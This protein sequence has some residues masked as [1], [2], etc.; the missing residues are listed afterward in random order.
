MIR[1]WNTVYDVLVE[2]CGA[3]RSCRDMFLTIANTPNGFYTNNRGFHEYRFQGA[4]GFGGKLWQNHE[5]RLHVDCY[6]E[7]RTP[8]RDLMI[9]RANAR[10]KDL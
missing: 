7:D 5:L 4:L 6:T 1:N 10:L 2:E 8:E 9:A 3:P